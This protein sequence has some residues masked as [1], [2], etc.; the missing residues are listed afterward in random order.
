MVKSAEDRLWKALFETVLTGEPLPSIV[1][2]AVT[3]IQA[4]VS[5]NS[6]GCHP[7]WFRSGQFE[8]E[9]LFAVA[10]GGWFFAL[11]PQIHRSYTLHCPML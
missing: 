6:D 7:S 2:A 10:D 5:S 1:K 9:A 8:F 3:D 4:M 11:H